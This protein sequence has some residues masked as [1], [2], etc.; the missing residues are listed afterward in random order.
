CREIP[1]PV[2]RV[3]QVPP[4]VAVI[5]FQRGARELMPRTIEPRPRAGPVSDPDNDGH[6]VR[7]RAKALF[8]RDERCLCRLLLRDL[9]PHT[10]HS[11]GF[12]HVVEQHPAV[13]RYPVHRPGTV[14]YPVLDLYLAAL[15]RSLDR[16]ADNRPVFG[17]YGG[18][19]AV[20]CTVELMGLQAVKID[21]FGRPAHLTRFNLPVPAAH[22]GSGLCKAKALFAEPQLLLALWLSLRGA[23]RLM[24]PIGRP[25]RANAGEDAVTIAH[26]HNLAHRV[27]A[28]AAMRTSGGTS[29]AKYES[30][31]GMA[32]AAPAAPALSGAATL[33]LGTRLSSKWII[34]ASPRGA[35]GLVILLQPNLNGRCFSRDN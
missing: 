24:R 11:V 3:H 6:R 35:M 22:A 9:D 27:P 23:P 16:G 4:T 30:D 25:V 18:D 8:T 31:R 20:E 28:N 26:S 21:Q 32:R 14:A 1:L 34:E 12:V 33:T 5:L 29:G 15:P 10:D 13:R 19:E 17:D 2:L 7:N